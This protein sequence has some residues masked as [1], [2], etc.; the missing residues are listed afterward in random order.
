MSRGGGSSTYVSLT[1]AETGLKFVFTAL[2][3]VICGCV[4]YVAQPPQL[5]EHSR[6]LQERR[7]DDADIASKMTDGLAA[8]GTRPWPPAHYGMAD[9][10]AAAIVLNPDLAEARAQLAVAAA[11]TKTARALPNPTIGLALDH[12][13]HAQSQDS[14]W[15]WGITIDLLIDTATQRRL[16]IS[17]AQTQVQAARLDYAERLW[18]V[19]HDLNAALN[20]SRIGARQLHLA[21]Q[22]VAKATALNQAIALRVQA[23]QAASGE[24]LQTQLAV[25]KALQDEAAA[26]QRTATAQGKL[27][28]ALGL[29][30]AAVMDISLQ[31]PNLSLAIVSEPQRWGPA[32]ELALLSRPDLERALADYNAR[33]IELHQQ[34][35][36]QYPQLSIGPGY[37]Y[38]HGFRRLTLNM[39]FSLPVFNRNEGPIA[40][41][42]ALR[43]AAGLQLEAVQATILTQVDSAYAALQQAV[44]SLDAARRQRE[45]SEQVSG[46]TQTAYDAGIADRVALLNAQLAGFAA[47][48]TELQA[49]DQMLQAAANLEDALRTPLDAEELA[50]ASVPESQHQTR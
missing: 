3:I 46:E 11:G 6:L 19:R 43:E 21:E 9:L 30:V 10:L 8:R 22:A 36:A 49:V 40:Q 17:L 4:R 45:L 20:D 47:A 13:L 7:L 41:A 50:L 24:Q 12:Y 16:R 42:Q 44:H 14:P 5:A 28:R 23:G 35:R 15:L 38:D 37:T 18:Q 48:Q 33:E 25:A 34:V 27:A 26:R 39:S 1:A 32:R 31:E 29:S 2:C